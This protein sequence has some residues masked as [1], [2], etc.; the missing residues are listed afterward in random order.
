MEVVHA[1]LGHPLVPS[2]A[3]RV[4]LAP[5]LSAVLGPALVVAVAF[6]RPVGVVAEVAS[7][8]VRAATLGSR[9]DGR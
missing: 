1:L 3:W 4:A 6:Q 7:P 5:A 8:A 2:A 9:E